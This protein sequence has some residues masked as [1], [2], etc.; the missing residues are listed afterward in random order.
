MVACVLLLH[1]QKS[2]KTAPEPLSDSQVDGQTTEHMYAGSPSPQR[3][4][5][6]PVLS[7]AARQLLSQAG[8]AAAAS[9]APTARGLRGQAATPAPA[10][11]T[12]VSN[13]A[14]AA[15][16]NFE[17]ADAFAEAAQGQQDHPGTA[18]ADVTS[19]AAQLGGLT[20]T[21][22]QW[23]R[24]VL[25][26]PQIAAAAA[27]TASAAETAEGRASSSP[28]A[29][30]AAEH[31]LGWVAP[32]STVRDE[33][34]LAGS[35]TSSGT[36][37]E[38]QTTAEAAAAFAAALAAAA[39]T[40]IA[41]ADVAKGGE[42]EQLSV[43]PAG[44]TAAAD[45]LQ[46]WPSMQSSARPSCHTDAID[47]WSADA[48]AFPPDSFLPHGYWPLLASDAAAGPGECCTRGGG[49]EIV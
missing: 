39:T 48:G 12:A 28:G 47:T 29:H 3:S 18:T 31:V 22:Q 4:A 49:G 21:G 1:L 25:T 7:P 2:S 44:H 36:Q 40:A 42:G 35:G 13:G 20:P 32:C 11:A 38:Y 14:V 41:P 46:G 23:D 9:A 6:Q 16:M 15:S 37:L 17:A 19:A 10:P 34:A 43:M 24:A 8:A 5:S 33:A 27:A 45:V 30:V 26:A